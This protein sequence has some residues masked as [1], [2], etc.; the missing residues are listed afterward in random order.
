MKN[1]LY[2]GSAA[3]QLPKEAQLQRIRSVIEQELSELQRQTLIDY[4]FR[5]MTISQIAKIRGVH[6]S[7]VLRTLRR[8][9]NNLRTYLKY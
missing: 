3:R 6:K 8:A 2:S 7:T 5:K 1:T 4:Y 9:E